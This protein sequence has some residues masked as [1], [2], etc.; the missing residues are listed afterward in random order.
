LPCQRGATWIDRLQAEPADEL[1]WGESGAYLSRTSSLSDADRKQVL[2]L[3]G[4]IEPIRCGRA[5]NSGSASAHA[6]C[7]T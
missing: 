3:L 4:R 6:A 2:E 7:S 5:G 1:T